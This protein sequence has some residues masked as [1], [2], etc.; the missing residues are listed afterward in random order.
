MFVCLQSWGPH[1]AL[2]KCIAL[3][4]HC[5]IT[6]DFST[7]FRLSA[8]WYRKSTTNNVN[9]DFNIDVFKERF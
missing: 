1:Q 5:F 6:Q 9:S 4:K 7:A 8:I 2:A 3:R